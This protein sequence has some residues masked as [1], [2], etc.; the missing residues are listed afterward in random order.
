MG[1][2]KSMVAHLFKD[3][4][5]VPCYDC[6]SWA[7]ALM[8]GSEALREGIHEIFS[9]QAYRF[10]GTAWRL[11]REHLAERIFADPALR[12]RLERVV[13]PAV[14][15]HFRQWAKSQ[16]A[17][18]VL[19]ESAILF[20]S[21]AH[22]GLDSII[23]VD[24]PLEL[25]IQRVEQRDHAGQEQIRRRIN[26]QYPP[27]ELRKRANYVIVNDNQQLLIPQIVA[28]DEVLRI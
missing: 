2:G 22:L 28:L 7:K 12:L 23:M 4:F 24:A 27:Q 9:G 1:C 11:N 20:E 15:E 5:D 25:R 10:D 18:Y 17:P 21:N 8:E 14:N 16:E 13:H 26:A 6:D 3:L 19:K